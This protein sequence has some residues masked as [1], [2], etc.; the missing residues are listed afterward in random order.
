[1]VKFLQGTHAR[2][3]LHSHFFL[4]CGAIYA[5]DLNTSPSFFRP[6]GV[7]MMWD[8]NM[9]H[10]TQ[11][12]EGDTVEMPMLVRSSDLNEELGLVSHVFRC[13]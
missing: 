8:L 4:K 5:N 13:V 10:E 9:Y 11:D 6:T 1:M 3:R 2:I 12:V 7:M